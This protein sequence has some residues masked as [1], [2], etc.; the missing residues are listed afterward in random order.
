MILY[1][2]RKPKY[3]SL[4]GSGTLSSTG[5]SDV[6]ASLGCKYIRTKIVVLNDISSGLGGWSGSSAIYE[7]NDGLHLGQIVVLG[8]YPS[9]SV[10][11]FVTSSNIALYKSTITAILNKYPKINFV[12]VDNEEITAAYHSGPLSDYGAM[13]QAVYEV[14]HPR[15]IKVADGGIYG[16]G[17]NILVYRWLVI[18][19]GQ[20]TADTFGSNV[21]SGGQILAAKTPNSNAGLEAL[22]TQITTILSYSQYFDYINIHTYEAPSSTGTTTITPNMIR[23]QKEYL[24]DTIKKPVI[25]NETGQ[26]NNSQPLLV[27]NMMNEFYRLKLAVVQWWDGTGTSGATP[28]TDDNTGAILSNGAA[29]KTFIIAHK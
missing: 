1:S 10:Q 26:R 16:A 8:A 13:L 29:F 27:T 20:S 4:K 2:K 28:L 24:E 3:G 6:V 18:K 5:K 25:T 15:N 14:C 23:F 9:G 12:V 11:P 17:L 22:A 21:M 19:Y 7:Y